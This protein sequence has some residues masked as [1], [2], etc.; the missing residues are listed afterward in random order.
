MNDED[1]HKAS[2]RNQLIVAF[3]VIIIIGGILVNLS[4][5]YVLQ[6]TLTTEQLNEDVVRKIS[7][8]FISISSGLTIAGCVVVLIIS[9]LLSNKITNPVRK[10]TEAV[11]KLANGRLHTRI[12]YQSDDEIGQL[13]KGF[14]QMAE[15]LESAIKKSESQREYIEAIVAAVPSILIIINERFEILLTNIGPSKIHIPIHPKEIVDLLKNEISRCLMTGE[16]EIREITIPYLNGTVTFLAEMGLIEGGTNNSSLLISLTDITNIKRAE[17][18]L[19]EL[20]E[21]LSQAKREWELAFDS[22]SNPIFLH[23]TKFRI[24]RANKAYERIAGMGYNMF[25]GSPYNQIF[26]IMDEPSKVCLNAI[27]KGVGEE[28]ISVGD[29]VFK[30]RVYPVFDSDGKLISCFHVMEDITKEKRAEE[31]IRLERDISSSLL[32][33]AEA[34]ARTTN[35]DTL[36]EH[37]VKNVTKIIGCDICL[38]YLW[39]K[40]YKVFR[41]RHSYG[42]S[43]ELNAIFKTESINTELFTKVGLKETDSMDI[44]IINISTGGDPPFE[45]IKGV[46]TSVFMPL[47]GRRTPL[48]LI[49]G[50]YKEQKEFERR[51]HIIMRGI[52]NQ[53]SIALEEAKLYMETIEKT[54]ELSHKIETIQVMH[55]ID[56]AVL[57]TIDRKEIIETSI[58][59]IRKVVPLCDASAI[60]LIDKEYGCLRFEAGFGIDSIKG[61]YLPCK[62]IYIKA[63]DTGRIDYIP[64]LR[65]LKNPSFI[66][67]SLLKDGIISCLLIPLIVEGDVTGLHIIGSRRQS[68]FTQGDLMTTQNISAQITVALENARLLTNLKELFIGTIKTLSEAIDA[69]SSWTRG[70]SERITDYALKIG[71]AIGMNE[72]ELEDIR[73]AGLLHDIGKL[74]TY[75]VILNK[76]GKLTDEEYNMVKEHPA[77]SARL[78]SPIRQL[79]HIIPW[80]R[81]H[82]ERWDG[83]GYPDGLKG[84]DIPLQARILMVADAF[85]SMTVSRPYRYAIGKEKAIEELKRCSGTQFDPQVVDV[86]IR[87]IEDG[88]I[89]IHSI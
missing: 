56:R 36:M 89:T 33:M 24:I 58:R 87:C 3:L 85:D 61:G 71:E 34:V 14:N 37:T 66:E 30:G 4:F 2:L 84:E 12:D 29:M 28:E 10:L 25:I 64:D 13:T 82:H 32:T 39:D 73:I 35:I 70:H 69:K 60:L 45:W 79:K 81:H 88:R 16:C 78:L 44:G 15:A 41:P 51:D 31:E 1:R 55:E 43:H 72:K 7:S 52:S 49:I 5:Q 80:I 47:K 9:I 65:D 53:V 38:F 42:L 59:M 75:D 57:S 63:I 68:A 27:E 11:N 18:D 19:Y 50:L 20:T 54:M 83:S 67:S 48:G 6:K 86:F 40:D 76:D 62:D 26:P 74:G 22:I 46:S 8:N 21:K 17:K 23:D 77:N